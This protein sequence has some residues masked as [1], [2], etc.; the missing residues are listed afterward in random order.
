MEQDEQFHIVIENL[1]NF[2][3]IQIESARKYETTKIP[4]K[5]NYFHQ[6][7]NLEIQYL[8][9]IFLSKTV[10]RTCYLFHTSYS[11]KNPNYESMILGD[12][13]SIL[14]LINKLMGDFK[15]LETRL[16]LKEPDLILNRGKTFLDPMSIST[17]IIGELMTDSKSVFDFKYSPSSSSS[18]F[19]FYRIY[20]ETGF[21]AFQCV[22]RQDQNINDIHEDGPFLDY[23]LS[24]FKDFDYKWQDA[25]YEVLR[26]YNQ[27]DFLNKF[28]LYR[29]FVEEGEYFREHNFVIN[30]LIDCFYVNSETKDQYL[31]NLINFKG[32]YL[33]EGE[34][35]QSIVI[36]INYTYLGKKRQFIAGVVEN[37]DIQ[38]LSQKGITDALSKQI[39]IYFN[40]NKSGSFFKKKKTALRLEMVG[41]WLIGGIKHM[42]KTTPLMREYENFNW[43][44][45]LFDKEFYYACGC[46]VFEEKDGVYLFSR[47]MSIENDI[48]LNQ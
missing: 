11:S 47:E 10:L 36:T 32:K 39:E 25:F 13:L 24:N 33:Y 42:F 3:K 14:D 5:Q 2:S 19:R 1:V 20:S 40:Q 35:T 37:P 16:R 23:K 29:Q 28:R 22:G 45:I 27:N 26:D 8:F 41:G 44:Q 46:K 7:D 18:Y 12:C 21:D 30:N 43:S 6:T 17:I 38:I 48:K 34:K 4:Q 15:D 9:N 31:K